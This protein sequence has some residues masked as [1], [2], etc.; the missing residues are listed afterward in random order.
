MLPFGG[1]R[2]P[3][4]Y[5]AF[6]A[7]TTLHGKTTTSKIAGETIRI[8]GLGHL[9]T[10]DDSTPQ[11]FI[12]TLAENGV[13]LHPDAPE[14]VIEAAK[15]R[16]L[17]SGQRGWI[18]E[19][20]GEKVSSMMRDGSAMAGYRAMFLRFDDCPD[21]YE[22][23]TIGRA[24][25]IIENPY[26]SL[27]V[28]VT[29]AYLQPFAS[30]GAPL[31]LDGTWARFA[32]LT[33]PENAERKRGRF[34]EGERIIPD[35]IIQPLRAWHK[36]LDDPHVAQMEVRK[37]TKD[38][39]EGVVEGIRLWRDSEKHP[40]NICTLAVGVVDAYYA[41]DN[42]LLDIAENNEDLLGNYGRLAEK[43]LRVAILFANLEND[44]V[45]KMKHWARTQGITERHR[46]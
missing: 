16:L 28:N 17:F 20:F 13:T 24:A 15:R 2:Y 32:F 45:I 23:K 25:D 29:P 33:P 42:A 35:S 12:Q 21:K 14:H 4:L 7:S 36:R 30:K 5:I 26:L 41:Y 8:A 19:E 31:W 46:F 6:A 44:G 10:P 40:V 18:F 1:R 11:A 9:L 34:P 27:L 39:S 43:A 22:Y 37:E 38:G 3:N